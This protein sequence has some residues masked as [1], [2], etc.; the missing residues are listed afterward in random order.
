MIYR[1]PV[2][3]PIGW[4]RND[5]YELAQFK[6]DYNT[7][8]RHLSYELERLGAESAYIS[9]DRPLR[10]DGTPRADRQPDTPAVAVYF[11][12]TASSSASPATSSAPSATI[13]VP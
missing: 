10:V 8:L 2:Q 3:W 7:A 4:P 12:A 11:V 1:Y 9:S 6:V 13:S 5:E